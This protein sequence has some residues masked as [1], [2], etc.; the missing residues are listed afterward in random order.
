MN[1]FGGVWTLCVFSSLTYVYVQRGSIPADSTD[2]AR[3]S[4][5]RYVEAARL[6]CLH[7]QTGTQY[8]RRLTC[9]FA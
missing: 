2:A 9:H 6:R 3:R 8:V 4:S 1:S 7:S 5:R